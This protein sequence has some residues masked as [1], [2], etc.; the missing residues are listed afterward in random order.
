MVQDKTT[1]RTNAKTQG[2]NKTNPTADNHSSEWHSQRN[3]G[4]PNRH[5]KRQRENP[6]RNS[7]PEPKQNQRIFTPGLSA[8][9]LRA[10]ECFGGKGDD[11]LK[12]ALDFPWANRCSGETQ[13]VTSSLMLRLRLVTTTL[14]KPHLEGRVFQ[15]EFQEGFTAEFLTISPHPITWSLS[16]FHLL[17][18]R[19]SGRS[20]CAETP[21][22]HKRSHHVR[23][24][25]HHRSTKANFAKASIHIYLSPL[26]PTEDCLLAFLLD[27]FI[28]PPKKKETNKAHVPGQTRSLTGSG[29]M[30]SEESLSAKLMGTLHSSIWLWV[31]KKTPRDHRF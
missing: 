22:G 6:K 3:R 17:F 31:K 10:Y 13:H 7:R 29:Q 28:P 27:P 26:R 24:C 2:E 4:K 21:R 23:R 9:V 5:P 1:A 11:T 8:R 30:V 19:W 20:T 15:L 12:S 18:I 16:L 25:N 14:Y